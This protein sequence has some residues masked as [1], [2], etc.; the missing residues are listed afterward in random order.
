MITPE[1]LAGFFD[2]EGCLTILRSKRHAHFTPQATFTNTDLRVL[3]LIQASY[4][5]TI[6]ARNNPKQWNEAYSLTFSG[7]QETRRILLILQPFL[8]LKKAEAD[9]FLTEWTDVVNGRQGK[10]VTDEVLQVRESIKQQLSA[11]KLRNRIP[12]NTN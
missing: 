3:Q 10:P 7:T 1:W 11:M 8:V 9:F 12:Q 5:G 4:G 2:G 6:H